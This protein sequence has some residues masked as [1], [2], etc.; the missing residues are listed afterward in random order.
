MLYK[1][2]ERLKRELREPLGDVIPEEELGER[3][4]DG[5]SIIAVGDMVAHTLFRMNIQ[6]QVTIIDFHTQRDEKV[7]FADD[8]RSMGEVSVEVRNPAGV[9]TRELWEAIKDAISSEKRVR[10]EVEGEEDLATIPCV[11]L[12]PNGTFLLYGLWNQGLVL[13]EITAGIRKRAETALKLMEV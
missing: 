10:I 7:T 8:L 2:P 6:P 1:L 5:A 11:M 12:A 3:L 9:I 13:V 4:P